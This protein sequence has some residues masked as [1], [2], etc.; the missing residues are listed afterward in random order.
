MSDVKLVVK[1][2]IFL[3]AEIGFRKALFFQSLSLFS[4]DGVLLFISS[5][6]DTIDVRLCKVYR[7]KSQSVA[8][9]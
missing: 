3:G 8:A 9:L 6:S 7:L 1:I 4:A 2:N 5:C